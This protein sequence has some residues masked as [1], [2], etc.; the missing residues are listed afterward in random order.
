MIQRLTSSPLAK[1]Q[2]MHPIPK[3]S[4][5]TPLTQLHDP[6]F[7]A[8]DIEVWVKRDD[9]NHPQ[10]Q[11][12]KWHKLKYNLHAAQQMHKTGLLTFGG[13]YSN[14]LAATAY[15]AHE[16]GLC[17]IGLI[18]GEELANAPERWSPT[19]QTAAQNGMQLQ[20]LSRQAYRQRHQADFLTQLQQKHP[21]YYLL[22]E[23][24]SN[25]LA[26]A[27]FEGLMQELQRQCPQWTHLYTAV[28]TGATLAGLVKFANPLRGRQ[29]RGVAVLRQAETLLPDIQRWIDQSDPV[30]WTLLTQYHHGGYAKSSPE[31]HAFQTAFET[32]FGI[33]LDPVYTLKMVHAFYHQ[34]HTG[35]IAKGA[36][37][38]LLHT[39]GL[40]GRTQRPS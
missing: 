29:I 5:A 25:A 1:T 11:G 15:A 6:L 12:N 14:H 10:I 36:K 39:G 38:V 2:P 28:G 35:G 40:Q 27:G 13:A 19:L 4:T 26:V 20:F 3:Q 21:H 7:D 30:K 34:L 23:G 16:A 24:G 37:V 33:P 32:R 8:L 17:S 22:P 9:L 31:L 18:R